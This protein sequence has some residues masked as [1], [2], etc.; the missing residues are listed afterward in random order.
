M[1]RLSNGIGLQPLAL[2]NLAGRSGHRA[3]RGT[4]DRAIST[5][6]AKPTT[7]T[8]VPAFLATHLK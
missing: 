1:A 5:P 4:N 6:L 2:A 7:A 8:K 3:H